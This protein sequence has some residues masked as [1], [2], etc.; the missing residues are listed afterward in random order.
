LIAAHDRWTLDL[1]CPLHCPETSQPT[2]NNQTIPPLFGCLFVP[3]CSRLHKFCSS[4]LVSV[5]DIRPHRAEHPPVPIPISRWPS[6][7]HIPISDSGRPGTGVCV[8]LQFDAHVPRCPCPLPFT[9][10][11]QPPLS[12]VP[13]RHDPPMRRIP[14]T[15]SVD[16]PNT[17][18]SRHLFPT[19]ATNV[20]LCPPSRSNQRADR[21]HGLRPSA[22]PR[23]AYPNI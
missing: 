8:S 23:R 3:I 7:H 19:A 10:L 22:N 2:F 13:R 16:R 11:G 1:H 21:H 6:S 20:T 12:S 4:L 9:G 14:S 18:S 17:P 15:A 5:H